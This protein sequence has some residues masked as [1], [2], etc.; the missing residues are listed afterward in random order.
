[1][2]IMML[3]ILFIYHGGSLPQTLDQLDNFGSLQG[4]WD[5]AI[6]DSNPFQAF[7]CNSHRTEIST[8]RFSLNLP[9]ECR[10]SDESAYH[11]PQKTKAKILQ[12]M[13]RIPIRVTNYKVVWTVL[14]GW[15]GTSGAWN[16]MHSFLQTHQDLIQT[17]KAQ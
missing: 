12:K 2:A 15:C 7:D 5:T 6:Q 8:A 13:E 16:F 9:P 10:A 4:I 14:V 3:I 11:P 17:T 1:M